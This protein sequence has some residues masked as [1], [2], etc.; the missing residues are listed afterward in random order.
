[1]S[2]IPATTRQLKASAAAL[3][4]N[5]ET[6]AS[7]NGSLLLRFYSVECSMKERYLT[8]QR[9]S[10][11]GDTSMLNG[12]FGSDGHDLNMGLK[13]LKAP[14]TLPTAPHLKAQVGKE[15]HSMSVE[16]AH[17]LWRYGINHEGS[18][19]LESWLKQVTGWLEKQR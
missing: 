3:Q 11:Q 14:A 7:G 18:P 13:A 6:L 2:Q 4:R 5:A 1:M 8:E 16:R 12:A 19:A 17:Q 9:A 15:T 10:P